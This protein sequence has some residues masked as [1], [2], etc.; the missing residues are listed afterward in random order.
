MHPLGPHGSVGVLG[1]ILSCPRR[2]VGYFSPDRFALGEVRTMLSRSRRAWTG[3]VNAGFGAQQVGAA[4]AMQPAWRAA[5]DVQYG[6]ATLNRIVAS[7]GASNSAASST[8]GAYR[9]LTAAISL[10]IG[11]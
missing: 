3:R 10:R 6:W 9:Y 11:I 2:G 7:I 1:R 5:G 4:G 8:T